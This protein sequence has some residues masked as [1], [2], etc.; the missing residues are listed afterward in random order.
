MTKSNSIKERALPVFWMLLF[1]QHGLAQNTQPIRFHSFVLGASSVSITDN[2]SG[3]ILR[4]IRSSELAYSYSVISPYRKK[5]IVIAWNNGQAGNVKL[6]DFFAA[7]A[8]AFS[9]VKNKNG[10]FNTYLGYAIS[11]NPV[12]ITKQNEGK[13]YSWATSTSLSAYSSS[14]YSWKNNSIS[15]DLSVPVAGF[16]SR[17]E[18]SKV[19]SG[20]VNELLYESHDNLFFT[21][22][23][24]LKPRQ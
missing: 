10:R 18:S 3:L 6:N 13:Q 16:A 20:N 17:P 2:Y 1:F 21:S 19:Y 7:Y 8:D 4:G 9:V 12:F 15:L 22:S 5:S 24:I 11:T 14:V 23:T